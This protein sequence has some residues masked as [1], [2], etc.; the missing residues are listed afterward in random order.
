MPRA[1]VKNVIDEALKN[2]LGFNQSET[3]DPL[4]F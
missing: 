3:H 4:C 1:D 2:Y